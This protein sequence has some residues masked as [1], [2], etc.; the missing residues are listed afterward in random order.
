MCSACR[1]LEDSGLAMAWLAV[2]IGEGD[3]IGEGFFIASD[4][5]EAEGAW[6][7]GVA[8]AVAPAGGEVSVGLLLLAG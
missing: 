2:V 5:G 1:M 8:L 3:C 7:T 6:N 4:L